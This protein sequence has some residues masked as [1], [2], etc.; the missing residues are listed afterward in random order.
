[1]RYFSTPTVE[2]RITPALTLAARG[3][4]ALS[5]VSPVGI[6]SGSFPTYHVL[7]G[8]TCPALGC[9][10]VGALLVGASTGLM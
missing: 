3:S 8:G 6:K 9:S 7:S 10:K 2:R 1:M 5:S 4:V